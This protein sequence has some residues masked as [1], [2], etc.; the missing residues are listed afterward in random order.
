M[1]VTSINFIETG[2]IPVKPARNTQNA[3]MVRNILEN[4][5]KAKDGQSLVLAVTDMAKYERYNLQKKLQSAGAKVL[6]SIG[7]HKDTGKEVLFVRKLS[8]KEWTEYTKED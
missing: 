3:Q 8:N 1:K 2:N 4:L 5:G 6:V 7:T